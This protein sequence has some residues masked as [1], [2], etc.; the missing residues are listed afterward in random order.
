MKEVVLDPGNAEAIGR[1]VEEESEAGDESDIRFRGSLGPVANA[2]GLQHS[3]TQGSR[4]H[5]RSP[6]K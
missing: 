6:F 5:D 4:D 1:A 3:L 2:P